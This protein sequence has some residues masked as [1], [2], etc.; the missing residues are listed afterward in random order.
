MKNTIESTLPINLLFQ[1]TVLLVVLLVAD[2]SQATEYPL[3]PGE[4]DFQFSPSEGEESNALS[5]A[6]LKPGDQIVLLPGN[7]RQINLR[8]LAG[9][10][11]QPIVIRSAFGKTG[12][13]EG[14]PLDHS[15]KDFCLKISDSKHVTIKNLQ[16]RSCWSHGIK[17]VDSSYIQ[18]ANNDFEGGRRAIEVKGKTS[19]H[20]LIEGNYWNQD[21]SGKIW[22][23]HDW[24]E[25]HHGN[26]KHFNGALFA[27]RN[28]LGYVIIRHNHIENSFNGIR[29]V[30]DASEKNHNSNVYI[31]NNHFSRIRDNPIE[32]EVYAKNWFIYS[33]TIANA[34]AWF[35]FDRVEGGNIFLYNNVGWTNQAYGKNGDHN[36][37]CIIKL[38]ED[39]PKLSEPM[40]I[41]DNSWYSQGPL[42]RKRSSIPTLRH[43]NNAIQNWRNPQLNSGPTQ[44]SGTFMFAFNL[45]NTR[46]PSEWFNP[47]TMKRNHQESEF[48]VNP[49]QGDLRLTNTSRG[50]D[51]GMTSK[52]LG[53]VSPYQGRAS[54]IGAFEKGILK[55]PMPPEDRFP[56]RPEFLRLVDMVMDQDNLTVWFSSALFHRTLLKKISPELQNQNITC[57][58]KRRTWQCNIPQNPDQARKTIYQSIKSNHPKWTWASQPQHFY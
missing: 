52:L 14:N 12:S 51:G 57:T 16:F 19:H 13:F 25:L 35:S 48:F 21:P 8:H 17:V 23:Q 22:T 24:A 9:T 41:F 38:A 3:H 27:S 46:V 47:N 10:I 26:L 36:S 29:M 58:P 20:F 1:T 7:H 4:M 34:H 45:L 15:A 37:G 55:H 2:H 53:W 44:L 30:G 11:E 28:I 54:D 50:N 56:S 6:Y 43:W 39:Q 42:F 18:I 31:Y 40:F 32:P 5:G 49:S 33:N